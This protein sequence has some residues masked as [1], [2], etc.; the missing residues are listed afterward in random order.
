MSGVFKVVIDVDRLRYKDDE[1][2]AQTLKL[3]SRRCAIKINCEK[4]L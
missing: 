1:T 2:S 3:V 4:R